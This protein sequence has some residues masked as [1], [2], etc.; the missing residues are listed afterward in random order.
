MEGSSRT[1]RIEAALEHRGSTDICSA[2]KRGKK[3]FLV[4]NLPEPTMKE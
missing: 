1:Q 2:E 3:A 4:E